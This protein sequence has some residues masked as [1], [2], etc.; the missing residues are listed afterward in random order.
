ML[1]RAL[2]SEKNSGISM[3]HPYVQL[4]GTLHV[5]VPAATLVQHAV[6]T[7]AKR[8]SNLFMGQWFTL[9][10]LL[11][12]RRLRLL[13]GAERVALHEHGHNLS[14]PDKCII[15]HSDFALACWHVFPVNARS[16]LSLSEDKHRL[17]DAGVDRGTATACARSIVHR[18][19]VSAAILC[20]NIAAGIARH[21]CWRLASND[22]LPSLDLSLPRMSY[23]VFSVIEHA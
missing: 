5:D 22:D 8:A 2:Q 16:A 12:R 4:R 7:F 17:P 14:A 9:T 23:M 18:C 21:F 20:L 19:A 1:S 15:L 11:N 3:E 6:V 10:L 13:G